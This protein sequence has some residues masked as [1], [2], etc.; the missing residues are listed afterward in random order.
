MGTPIVP[1]SIAESE[2]AAS[3]TVKAQLALRDLILSGELKP[4]DRIS[5]LS[6]V[7]RL[8][9]SR[10]PSARRWRGSRKRAFWRRSRPAAL[11]SRHSPNAISTMLSN[12][13][14]RS[15]ASR[16][17]RGRARRARLADQGDA[18]VLRRST[19]SPRFPS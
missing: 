12:C 8:G 4:G 18:D 14:A 6:L 15:K 3:Q 7:D 16:A 2:R 11:P 19:T 1:T 13:A 17:D 10:T 9:M 5:E